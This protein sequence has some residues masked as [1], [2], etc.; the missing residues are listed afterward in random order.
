MHRVCLA[1]F[2]LSTRTGGLVINLETADMVI[3]FDVSSSSRGTTCKLLTHMLRLD[4]V[5]GTPQ[6][7]L[8]AMAR[9]HRICMI[10]FIGLW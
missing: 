8:Q 9:A 5:I 4:R 3:V 10:M 2:L 6:N 7:D 1:A